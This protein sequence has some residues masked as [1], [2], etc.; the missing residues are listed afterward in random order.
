[1]EQSIRVEYTT[2]LVKEKKKWS[3]NNVSVDPR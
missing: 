3:T 2:S 1:M